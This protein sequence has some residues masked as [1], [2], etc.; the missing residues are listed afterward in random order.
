MKGLFMSIIPNKNFRLDETEYITTTN[1][2]YYFKIEPRELNQILTNMGWIKKKHFIWWIATEL[3]KKNGAKE[4]KSAHNRLCYVYWHKSVMQN[5]EL[6]FTIE[7]TV[8]SY[9]DNN[10]YEEFIKE[11][12][13]QQEYTVWHYAKDKQQSFKNENITLVAK[14]DR[15][16][17]LIHCRDNQLDISVEELKN[18]Q[19][20]RDEFKLNNPVFEAYD[21]KLHYCM[22]GFFM[23][24]D[25]YEY[26]QMSTDDISYEIIKGDSSSMWLDSLLL[27]E[28]NKS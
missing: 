10:F 8:R 16:I 14:K 6:L 20:Q 13:L 19:K 12:Y 1:L 9:L 24:E 28:N 21:L 7:Q 17:I 3:G 25:A 27:G 15:E 5:E 18:F 11:Y 22:S 23:T 26:T 4:Y 2:A